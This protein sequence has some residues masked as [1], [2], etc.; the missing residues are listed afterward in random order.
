MSKILKKTYLPNRKGWDVLAD[1]TG[2]TETRQ[3]LFFHPGEAEPID[4]NLVDKF[5]V[6]E[7]NVN[8]IEVPEK[9][10]AESEVTQILVDKKY[11]T[12]EQTISDLPVKELVVK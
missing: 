12:A 5:T 6:L 2:I 8:E 10:Y 4:K 7:K 11:I 9:V 1:I 3:V